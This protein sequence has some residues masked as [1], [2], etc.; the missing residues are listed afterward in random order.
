MSDNAAATITATPEQELAALVAK[1]TTLSRVALDL[2]A[3]CL[4]INQE[5]PRVIASQV[6]AA[7]AEVT[8]DADFVRGVPLTPDE[9]DALYWHRRLPD[10]V[11][12]D[13]R[14]LAG[15]VPEQ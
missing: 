11:C 10:L 2:T 7:V 1:V 5:L 15:V 13:H 9:L 3:K 6:A 8:P 12:R 14:A 4:D